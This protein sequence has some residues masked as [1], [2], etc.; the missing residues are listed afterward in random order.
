MF[1][2]GAA[3]SSRS[4]HHAPAS[5]CRASRQPRPAAML[6]S[7]ESMS[8]ASYGNRAPRVSPRRVPGARRLRGEVCC[9]ARG[10]V[11]FLAKSIFMR[12]NSGDR[13]SRFR[14]L[15]GNGAVQ[16]EI[17]GRILSLEPRERLRRR[18]VFSVFVEEFCTARRGFGAQNSAKLT[19]RSGV[20]PTC[21]QLPGKATAD[22][23]DFAEGMPR[24][25]R[26]RRQAS[27]LKPQQDYAGA[28]SDS[29]G[30]GRHAVARAVRPW[31]AVNPT[32]KAP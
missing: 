6:L 9:G 21:G 26:L 11:R 31:K 29:P 19:C 30:E 13:R 23:A 20:R 4:A 2:G 12:Q 32:S 10:F 3:G 27:G 25:G 7:S 28:I 15:P 22:H 17:K 18:L 14:V 1:L 24:T 5:H 8:R 16:V